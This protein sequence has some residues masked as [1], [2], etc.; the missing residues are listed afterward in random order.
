MKENAQD[1]L[2]EEPEYS[3]TKPD[4]LNISNQRKDDIITSQGIFLVWVDW[5]L[6]SNVPTLLYPI[7]NLA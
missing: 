7:Y 3:R 1:N 2:Y 4:L 6:M 5:Q